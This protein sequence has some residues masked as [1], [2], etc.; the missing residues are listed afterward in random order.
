LIVSDMQ[1]S[2]FVS[3]SVPAFSVAS[4]NGVL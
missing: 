1:R 3:V 2:T 4:S